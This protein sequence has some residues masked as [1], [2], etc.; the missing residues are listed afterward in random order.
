MNEQQVH[1]DAVLRVV[2]G[3]ELPLSILGKGSADVVIGV[4][5]KKEIRKRIM[6]LE[7]E[8]GLGCLCD[9]HPCIHA[10]WES[11]VDDLRAELKRRKGEK[12]SRAELED[13]LQSVRVQLDECRRESRRLDPPEPDRGSVVRFSVLFEHHPLATG[14]D[15]R[16]TYVAA[17]VGELWY[18]TGKLGSFQKGTWSELCR[19][20]RAHDI[21]VDAYKGGA[22]EFEVL[23]GDWEAM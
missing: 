16:Y 2:T 1:A 20:Y 13:S 22:L 21:G 17:R 15:R 14:L 7:R 8:L 23:R 11:E 12:L 4:A 9:E 5:S 10:D 19:A 6:K 18:L 3:Y